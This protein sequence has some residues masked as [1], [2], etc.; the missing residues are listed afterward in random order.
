MNENPNTVK[1]A[2]I[3]SYD[4]GDPV[5]PEGFDHDARGYADPSPGWHTFIISDFSIRANKN[6]NGKDFGTW[7]GNQLEPRLVIPD[8]EPEAGASTLDFIPLPT[9]GQPMPKSLANRWANFLR[10]FGFQ[11]PPDQLVPQGFRLHNLLNGPR[12]QCEIIEDE[13]EGKKKMKPRFFGYRPLGEA[14]AANGNG[15]GKKAG[16]GKPAAQSATPASAAQNLA[17]LDI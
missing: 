11:C 7:V 14:A 1:A 12:G 15:N 17:D 5:A 8:G 3:D 10:A 6:F 9:P 13:W 16:N 2:D 4:F